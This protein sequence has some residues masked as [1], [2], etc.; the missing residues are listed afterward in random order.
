[1]RILVA[2]SGGVDSS[3]AAALLREEGHEVAGA[4]MRLHPGPSPGT[5]ARCGPDH[6]E[7]ARSAA[8][9]LGLPFQVLELEAPFRAQVV[10]PFVEAYLAGATPNP[11]VIC[12]EELKFGWLLRHARSQGARLATG[13]YARAERRGG[14]FALL[15]SP[16]PKDQSY[17]L[18]TLGQEVLRDVLFPLGALDKPEVRRLAALRGLQVARKA[19]S[20]EV[21]FI[22]GGGPQGFVAERAGGRLRGGEVVSTQGEVLGRHG[23]VH[24]FTVGQRRGLG[25]GGGP[26]RYVVRIEAPAGRVVV[27]TAEEA[28]RRR[29]AVEAVHWVAGPPPAG[30]LE[31]RV[32]VRHGHAGEA[33]VVVPAGT[34]AAVRLAGPVR[35]VA[36]GQAAVFYLGDEVLGGGRIS[37]RA[38]DEPE[39]ARAG[40]AGEST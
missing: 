8:L 30:P 7:D 13:H 27:G 32:K 15:A 14:R 35:G 23:G 39:P 17:F 36:P 2:M 12:N 40:A 4:F 6:L 33:G 3:L 37:D 9:A 34:C 10:E 11:C 38:E 28:S 26:P 31:V 18:Y 20:Q 21:C 16:G 25:L 29:F 19:D 1:M 22:P 5:S 24:A